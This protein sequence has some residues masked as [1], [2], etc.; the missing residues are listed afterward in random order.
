M[1]FLG[2]DAH[3]WETFALIAGFAALALVWE[4][5]RRRFWGRRPAHPAE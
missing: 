2:I 4:L 3:G 5:L 1:T